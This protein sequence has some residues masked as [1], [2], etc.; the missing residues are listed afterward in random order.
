[1][2]A[3]KKWP[4]ARTANAQ[5]SF[6]LF[7]VGVDGAKFE[8]LKMFSPRE[9]LRLNGLRFKDLFLWLSSSLKSVSRS[10]PG[11]EVPLQNPVA[12]GGWASIA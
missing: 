8:V 4:P 2:R 6:A 11:D 5:K 9:P 1:M 7:A 3:G 10:S 12:P